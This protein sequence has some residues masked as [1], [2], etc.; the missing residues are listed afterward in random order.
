[1][2]KAGGQRV[3]SV[4]ILR[5]DFIQLFFYFFTNLSIFYFLFI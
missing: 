1:M 3:N 4:L 5:N 2:Q